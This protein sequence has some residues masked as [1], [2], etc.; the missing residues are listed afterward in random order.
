MYKRL[1]SLFL[2]LMLSC[3]A[4]LATP[5]SQVEPIP[6]ESLPPV[7]EGQHHYLLLVTDQ[8]DYKRYA[9]GNTDG[10]LLLTLDTRAKRILLTSFSRDILVE[11]PDGIIGRITF[12]SKNFGPEK[13]C[14]IMSTH[15]GVRI[16]KYILMDLSK[17]ENIIDFMGGVDI[18]VTNAEAAYLKRYA[19]PKD[20]T[21]P[22]MDK[23]GTYNFLGHAAVIYMRIRKVGNGDYGRTQ[24]IRNTLSGL[25]GIAMKYNNDQAFRL[26]DVILENINR[27]NIS[28]NDL[29][30]AVGYALELR[31][32]SVEQLRIPGDGEHKII[33]Y[34]G[35]SVM[36]IDYE[37]ARDALSKF[38]DDSYVVID[39]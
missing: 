3:T 8:W 1:L 7:M 6:Y 30:K 15:F 35:M 39:D 34:A 5:P 10:I 31:G 21:V 32:A 14:E 33:S 16:E 9:I 18:S 24:R 27:T 26:L 36:D 23:A 38:L 17:V 20:S 37:K 13:L 12:I 25:A 11:R 19:I 28:T 22:Q 2:I 29:L 4:A